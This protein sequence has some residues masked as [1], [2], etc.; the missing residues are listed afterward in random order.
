MKSQSRKAKMD[1]DKRLERSRCE[2]AKDRGMQARKSRGYPKTTI[3]D[4]YKMPCCG[5][6]RIAPRHTVSQ[7]S[8]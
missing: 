8:Q 2:K 3:K 4:K 5:R 6:K 7:M 1:E